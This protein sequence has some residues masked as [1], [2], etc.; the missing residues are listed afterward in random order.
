MERKILLVED[1]P[2]DREIIGDAFK[3]IQA[4]HLL[5]F[6]ANGENALTYVNNM[7][8]SGNVP[9]LIV[10]DLNMPKMNGTQTLKL[11]KADPRFEKIPVIIFSTSLNDLEKKQ[12]LELGAHSYVIKPVY[13][14]ESIDTAKSFY[15]ISM[16][17]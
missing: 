3:S 5:H 8:N 12:C 11:L 17:L 9:S 16:E 13:F 14:Q 7:F 10:M 15:E 2:D 6:E 4:E 1:D